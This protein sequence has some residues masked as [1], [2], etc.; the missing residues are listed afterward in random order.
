MNNSSL[1]FIIF[2]LLNYL[3]IEAM[4]QGNHTGPKGQGPGTGRQ[5][6]YCS[7]FDSPGFVKSFGNGGRFGRGSGKRWNRGRDTGNGFGRGMGS[8]DELAMLKFQADEIKATQEAIQKRINEL[9]KN[10]Q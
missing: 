3:K 7:G 6:G 9:E 8:K 4:P 1:Q 10:S 5:R 2:V